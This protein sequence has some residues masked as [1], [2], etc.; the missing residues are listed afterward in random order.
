MTEAKENFLAQAITG[1][2][3]RTLS[4]RVV[5]FFIGLPLAGIG[6]GLIS[7]AVPMMMEINGLEMAGK[8]IFA[9]AFAQIPFYLGLLILYHVFTPEKKNHKKR[10]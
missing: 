1:K 6:I 3:E 8:F 4:K 7:G 9:M 10:G 2:Y 5:F